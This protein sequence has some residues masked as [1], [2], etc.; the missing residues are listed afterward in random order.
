MVAQFLSLKLRL[1]ANTFR[2]SPWQLVGVGI[3]L[4]YGSGAALLG[5]TGLVAL[6]V[7]QPELAGD[8]V[9]V[10]GSL[11][12]LGFLLVP[13]AFGVD[14]TLDPRR[15]ALLGIPSGR[16]ASL[17]ALTALIG[18]P[19]VGISVVAAAQIV[20]WSRGVLPTFLALLGGVL[21][22]VTSVLG[23]RVATSLAAMFLATRRAREISGLVALVGLVCLAPLLVLLANVDWR[24]EGLI[25]LGRV[26]DAASWTPL[27]A[28]WAAPSDA[29]NGDPSTA[30][31]KLF[32]AV[33]FAA[34]L[35]VAW[36]SLVARMLVSPHREGRARSYT[37]LGW[38]GRLPATPVWSVAARSLTYWARD[39]RYRVQLVV[40]PVVPVL[41]VI[42]FL[43]GGVYWQN[44]ALLPL[45]VMCLF[46]SWAPHNDVAFDSTAIWLHV[47]AN[48]RGLADRVGRIIPVLVI[49]I[50]L[51]AIGA[52]LSVSLYGD[53][54]ALP[55]MI[56]VS[57]CIL[58]AGLGLSSLLS[59]RFPYPAVRPGD[60]PFSQ[61]QASG[62]A[63]SLIQS[64]AFLVTVALTAPALLLG[65]MGLATGNTGDEPMLALL[66][67][68][69]VG[70]LMLVLGVVVGG[71]VFER[72]GPELLAFAQRN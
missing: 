48:T 69:G 55:S 64:L 25:V 27:G 2:R 20:T 4:L 42:T 39:A 5:V 17:L 66:A 59:A 29:A 44:L 41:M 13:L 62:G 19:A 31:T 71:R 34:L 12:V 7:V 30:I 67:G 24:G 35:W 58:F 49:G 52:P 37:G 8:I 56:G 11:I 26:A 61:P 63:A 51:I 28:A 36:R 33:G 1:L 38:F 10:V 54:A 43:V 14:D 21:I 16:L 18:V 9:I 3:A 22:V 45:P 15:F 47:S 57:G 23:G 60:S 46:L 70:S 68:L 32:L 40:V 72:R 50:P 53:P 65:F 6:R